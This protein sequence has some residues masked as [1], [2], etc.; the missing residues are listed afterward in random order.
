M[1]QNHLLHPQNQTGVGEGGG[2]VTWASEESMEG[3]ES[4]KM[5]SWEGDH[6]GDGPEGQRR[7]GQS[8]A[9]PQGKAVGSPQG[10][11]L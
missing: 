1:G 5:S 10:V 9:E 8:R 4:L 7:G 6:L 11:D 3:V 2:G